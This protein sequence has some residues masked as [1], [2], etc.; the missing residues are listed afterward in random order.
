M[1]VGSGLRDELAKDAFQHP[2]SVIDV[3]DVDAADTPDTPRS[4]SE[5]F[6]DVSVEFH[7]LRLEVW[8]PKEPR[9]RRP[10]PFTRK[11]QNL[12]HDIAFNITPLPIID[13]TL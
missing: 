13:E 11:T 5:C 7:H 4:R 12:Q 6:R 10:S 2:W 9:V 8:R 3:V 1:H